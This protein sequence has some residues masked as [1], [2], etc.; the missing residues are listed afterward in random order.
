M[1]TGCEAV[2][3]RIQVWTGSAAGHA[4]AV[5]AVNIHTLASCILAFTDTFLIIFHQKKRIS[6]ITIIIIIIMII[7]LLWYGTSCSVNYGKERDAQVT[8]HW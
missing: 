4:F 3:R 5:I 1:V 8:V 6:I 2:E 7:L